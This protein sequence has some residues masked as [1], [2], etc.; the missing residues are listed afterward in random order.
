M[1]FGS[2]RCSRRRADAEG[3][4]AGRWR[5]VRPGAD[6]SRPRLEHPAHPGE[7]QP[8]AQE[9][10]NPPEP[11]EVVVAVATGAAGGSGRGHEAT[12]LVEANVLLAVADQLGRDRDPVE[13]PRRIV[14]AVGHGTAPN[15][16]Q[17]VINLNIL[18]L[19][20]SQQIS[21]E[22][23]SFHPNVTSGG[24]EPC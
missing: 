1:R 4:S 6:R 19:W 8:V 12:P 10:G 24:N 11:T 3:V 7:V 16:L 17:P 22:W 9:F 13:T 21:N 20:Q 23:L 18:N 15:W 14:F 2:R 5:L